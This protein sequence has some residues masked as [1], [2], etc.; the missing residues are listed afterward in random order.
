M[1]DMSHPRFFSTL[2]PRILLLFLL[3]G[4]PVSGDSSGQPEHSTPLG[5]LP[6]VLDAGKGK[7]GFILFYP[8]TPIPADAPVVVFL[9]GYGGLNPMY[10]G[11]WIDYL[12]RTGRTVVFPYYQ[13]NL[14][15][16]SPDV[17]HLY[18]AQA[19]REALEILDGTDSLPSPLGNRIDFI[20]H[21]FGGAIGARLAAESELHGLP[22]VGNL[23]LAMAGTGPFRK[24][25]LD[26]YQGIPHDVRL[27]VV[28]A[29]NDRVVGSVFSELVFE[30]A[31]DVKRK[32][33]VTLTEKSGYPALTAGHNE[34][35]SRNEWLDNGERQLN[36]SRTIRS[37]NALDAHDSLAFWRTFDW[38]QSQPDQP[39]ARWIDTLA[40]RKL[41]DLG[42]DRNGYAYGWL[43]LEA[44]LL[45]DGGTLKR[46]PA[47]LPD[48]QA[49]V[50]H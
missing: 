49:E 26:T 33:W 45:T 2:V 47:R 36:F 8:T 4:M 17:F 14:F 35:C 46:A 39:D 15:A 6:G 22:P 41:A 9:H 19:I 20:G 28:V 43:D 40:L 5:H 32:L 18:A 11:G 25:R 42:C 44:I 30:T 23:F 21:S 7:E 38:M 31:I 34:V 24:G 13:D 48:P 16:P 10:Y 37:K 29:E 50:R 1:R 27:T 3:S 12:V